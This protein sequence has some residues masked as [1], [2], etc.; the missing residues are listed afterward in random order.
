[1]N[2]TSSIKNIKTPHI[3]AKCI[4]NISHCCLHTYIRR[5]DYINLINTFETV[6]DTNNHELSMKVVSSLYNFNIKND[7]IKLYLDKLIKDIIENE[8]SISAEKIKNC[9]EVIVLCSTYS[10]SL[11][12]NIIK[13][14]I[15]TIS[16]EQFKKL[17]SYFDINTLELIDVIIY[18]NLDIICFVISK[19]NEYKIY[20]NQ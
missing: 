2:T 6:L 9:K 19:N 16:L 3:I 7:F 12:K 20:R 5:L 1:M 10:S 17:I 13:N 11:F 4:K 8:T 15:S 14:I 18:A